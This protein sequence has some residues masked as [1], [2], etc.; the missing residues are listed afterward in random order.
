MSYFFMI[1]VSCDS[2]TSSNQDRLIARAENH[3]LYLS[4][5]E[6]N[7]KSFSSVEDSLIK[8]N[9][10]I[11]NWAR[12]KLLF[13][14]SL[15]NLP[16]E[17]ISDLSNLVDA[18]KNNLFINAYRE[19]VL[20]STMES[21]DTTSITNSFY[22]ANKEN[23]LLKEPIFRVRYISF[24]LD[25]VVRKE[26]TRRFKRYNVEDVRFLD[27]LSFQFSSYFLSDTIWLN[28]IEVG[29]QLN[30]LNQKQK[31][32]F[33]NSPNY[34]EVKDS[35]DIYLFK[36]AERLER[37][38]IAPISYVE[39]TIRDILFNQKKLELLRSFDN[40]VLQ[41]AIKSKKFEKY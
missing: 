19:F 23:F 22:E 5:L 41:D 26:I 36:L 30:N 34:F 16:Q 18:Y 24:P 8:A 33:L 20:K 9:N 21:F 13:E 40:D 39:N 3:Y 11:N 38:N 25:N 29:E 27:S 2:I 12:E 37:G 31:E 14:K 7:L 28:E 32:L 17:K 35:L 4:D 6:R 15:I 1:L 10:Y